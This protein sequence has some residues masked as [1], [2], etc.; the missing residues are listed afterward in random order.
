M[1]F[2][3]FLAG[4]IAKVFHNDRDKKRTLVTRVTLMPVANQKRRFLE[5][6]T[7]AIEGK[8][9]GDGRERAGVAYLNEVLILSE[10]E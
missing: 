10:L 9:V 4:Y 6:K 3:G 7:L 2:R 5:V 1:K 8:E